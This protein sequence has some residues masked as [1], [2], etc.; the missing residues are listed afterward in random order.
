MK[1]NRLDKT[2][3][4]LLETLQ[5]NARVSYSELAKIVN[6]SVPSVV[7]RV[8]KLEEMGL[9]LGYHTRVNLAVLGFGLKAVVR[10]S[11]TGSQMLEIARVVQSMPEVIEAHRMTGDTCFLAVVQVE[12][13]SHLETL[14]DRMSRYGQTQTSIVVSTPVEMRSVAE[15][16]SLQANAE[17]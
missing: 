8:R 9:I 10:F 7:E 1:T 11:G 6:L 17:N 5:Q 15:M 2:N 16:Q 4:K 3:W 13:T 14:L 12:S